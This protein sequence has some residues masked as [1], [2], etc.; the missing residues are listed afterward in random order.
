MDMKG[1]ETFL[2]RSSSMEV[3]KECKRWTKEENKRFESAL[4]IFDEKTPYRWYK[5]AEMIPGKSVHDVMNQYRELV[6]DVSDIEAGLV[7]IPG[8][9][10]SSF[11]LELP[12]F[13][14]YRKRPTTTSHQERKKGVPWTQEEHRYFL[15]PV[16]LYTFLKY[17]CEY[18]IIENYGDPS[19]YLVF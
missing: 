5:V 17:I 18:K 16:Q 6:A 12:D 8:Y 3:Q 7:P 4:A 2:C 1:M 9:L 15:R 11:T 10:A 19:Y 13:H 14:L